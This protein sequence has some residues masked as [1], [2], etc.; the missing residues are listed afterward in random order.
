[1]LAF[2]GLERVGLEEARAGDIVAL[3]GFDRATVA[4]TLCDLEVERA[5]EAQPIDPPTLAMTFSANNS[6]LAGQE[7]DSVTSR[8]IGERLQREAEGNVAIRVAR[9]RPAT[10]SRSPAAANCSSGC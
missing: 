2:R 5:I 10:A 3:A 4:D 8:L 6:P 9:R 1:M 7:G